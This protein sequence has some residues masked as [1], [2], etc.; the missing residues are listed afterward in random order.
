MS[1]V[2]TATIVKATEEAAIEAWQEYLR[3]VLIT[4][5]S[6][7]EQ[8]DVAGMVNYFT[9]IQQTPLGAVTNLHQWYW[10]VEFGSGVYIGK[11][12]IVVIPKKGKAIRFTKPG[13]TETRIKKR[14][15]IKGTRPRQI[16]QRAYQDNLPFLQDLYTRLVVSKVQAV[17]NV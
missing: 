14:A 2:N 13:G 9:L 16:L 12:P 15:V 4:A 7:A 10:A 8:E 5:K 3:R 6:L 17:L 1:A 11:P